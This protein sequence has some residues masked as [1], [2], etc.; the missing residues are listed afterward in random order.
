MSHLERLKRGVMVKILIA[1]DNTLLAHAL[2]SELRDRGYEAEV[3][4]AFEGALHRAKSGACDVILL[5]L[6]MPGMAG[7]HSVEQ[8]CQRSGE[9]KVLLF[10]GEVSFDF[11]QKA[12]EVGAWGYVP[13]NISF[14]AF[15]SVLELVNN[16]QKFLPSGLPEWASSKGSDF[17]GREPPPMKWSAP[18]IR[19]AED[20]RWPLR[21]P[22]PKRLS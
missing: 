6:D 20:L 1:N 7:L 8:M 9:S 3:V 2:A 12:M 10:S 17:T 19:K 21:D 18:I 11:V 16:G 4:P 14:S 22:S 13:K 15:Y 5:S